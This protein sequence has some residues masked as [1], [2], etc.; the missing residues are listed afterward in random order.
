MT[1][2]RIVEEMTD[3][4]DEFIIEA[5]NPKP[6][7]ARERVSRRKRAFFGFAFATIAI[8]A[9]IM[10]FFGGERM[11]PF[12]IVAYAFS[13]EKDTVTAKN[14]GIGTK[15]PIDAFELKN[16][17]TAFV[18]SCGAVTNGTK[19]VVMLSAT[20]DRVSYD[21]IL[22]I[23]KDGDADYYVYVPDVGE[24]IPYSVVF[25]LGDEETV[26]QYD[27]EILQVDGR[28]YAEMKSHHSYKRVNKN[29]GK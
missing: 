8:I 18:F 14:L 15:V 24:A 9:V 12:A 16:G 28:F 17:Q 1:I 23:T 29:N 25:S 22:E 20:A 6:L 19:S 5:E 2:P 7:Q 4:D 21:E 27:V 11:S 13:P 3:I 26:V 10:L